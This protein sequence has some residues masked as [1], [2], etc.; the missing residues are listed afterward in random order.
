MSG[1]EI[2]SAV[3]NVVTAVATCCAV[4]VAGFGLKT[5]KRE[6]KG[7]ADFD[8][9]RQMAK[10]TYSLRDAMTGYRSPL[11]L[12]HEF[13]NGDTKSPESYVVVFQNR[14][15]SVADASSTFDTAMLEA[16]A[17]WGSTARERGSLLKNCVHRLFV[18][19]A[20]FVDDK[21][22]NGEHF[23]ADHKFG[24]DMRSVVSGMLDDEKN[25]LST[26][27]SQAVSAIE[28]LLKPHLTRK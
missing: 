26:E 2:T 19:T 18:A 5:W 27:I 28:E 23:K 9:A 16:E 15:R 24:M 21:R 13:P 22:A 3:A 20:A 17:L 4:F 14:S 6:L 11:W 7:R 10:A 1:A 8:A 12:N 25:V